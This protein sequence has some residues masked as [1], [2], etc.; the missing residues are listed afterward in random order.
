MTH[1][2][3]TLA[4]LRRRLA[5]RD[6]HTAADREQRIDS[7]LLGR[8]AQ[9]VAEGHLAAGDL[10]AARDAYTIAARHG[11]PD[12]QAMLDAVAA[13]TEA[14]DSPEIRAAAAEH[15]LT[16]GSDTG[17]RI[18]PDLLAH[19]A[20]TGTALLHSIRTAQQAAEH[21]RTRAADTLTAALLATSAVLAD[22]HTRAETITAR[23]RADAART[24]LTAPATDV[25]IDGQSRVHAALALALD[26]L[27]RRDRHRDAFANLVQ[28]VAAHRATTGSVERAAEIARSC[29]IPGHPDHPVASVLSPSGGLIVEAKFV[30]PS[31]DVLAALDRFEAQLFV[32]GARTR[33]LW[34][35]NSDLHRHDPTTRPRQALD[36]DQLVLALTELA[37]HDPDLLHAAAR[38]A[39]HTHPDRRDHAHTDAQPLPA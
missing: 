21:D 23:A 20:L 37:D 33:G 3:P 15:A 30:H 27:H 24:S 39:R 34:L 26:R 29:A 31:A 11:A 9:A 13:L 4:D 28:G 1:N 32:S 18:E 12:A 35:P 19:R 10:D 2:P 17:G 38:H 22:A 16:G 6:P 8:D 25:V 14:A 5:D 36:R 7:W